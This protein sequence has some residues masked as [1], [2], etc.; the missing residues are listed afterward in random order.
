MIQPSCGSKSQT[1]LI[2]LANRQTGNAMKYT[3]E[4]GD[5]GNGWSYIVGPDGYREGP[6]RY[7]WE[8]EEW[9]EEMN[10]GKPPPS[11]VAL[12]SG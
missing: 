2:G 3:V 1:L 12:A 8:A 11:Y 4:T 7:R 5:N 10:N 6:I 9:A